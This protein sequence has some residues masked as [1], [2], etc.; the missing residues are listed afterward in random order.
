MYV[1]KNRAIL[2]SPV[3]QIL[4]YLLISAGWEF[5]ARQMLQR[6]NGIYMAKNYPDHNRI[7]EYSSM[8]RKD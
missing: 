2:I 7:R 4:L 6:K 1:S 3:I 8:T 5:L